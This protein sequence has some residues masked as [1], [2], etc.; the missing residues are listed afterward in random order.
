MDV[1]FASSSWPAGHRCGGSEEL[2]GGGGGAGGGGG[3]GVSVRDSREKVLDTRVIET[4]CAGVTG[5]V[6][7]A[8]TGER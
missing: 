6:L 5:Q 4:A 7:T 3:R 1:T 8:C 2:S